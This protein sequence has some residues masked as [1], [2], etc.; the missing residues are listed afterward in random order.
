[1]Q[2][3][4]ISEATIGLSMPVT[5]FMKPNTFHIISAFS[6]AVIEGTFM[7]DEVNVRTKITMSITYGSGFMA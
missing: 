1:M 3:S 7:G 6:N 5:G 2:G 4:N